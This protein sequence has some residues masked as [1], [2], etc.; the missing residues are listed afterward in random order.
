VLAACKDD[1]TAPPIDAFSLA[2]HVTQPDGTPV[3]GLSVVLWNL[4][5]S[6]DPYL[7]DNS[8]GRRR[9]ATVVDFAMARPALVSLK[10]YDLEGRLRQTVLDSMVLQAGLHSVVLGSGLE[11][12][13]GVEVLRYELVLHDLD[14]QVE[15]F[16]DENY[17]TAVHLDPAR[18][19][20]G[21]TDDDGV[22]ET[23]DR[24]VL[25][26]LYELGDLTATDENGKTTGSFTLDPTLVLRIYDD[27]GTFLHVETT[28]EDGPNRINALWDPS[29]LRREAR[30]PQ[31]TVHEEAAPT[32]THP[33]VPDF[34]LR[35]NYPNPFN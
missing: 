35:Q 26:G 34:E 27:Q 28:M 24:T 16:R 3:E 4:S 6:L 21:I 30:G 13:A 12:H 23:L 33:V 18:L 32:V 20:A 19:I 29:V 8:Q 7:Q 25:P 15:L 1:T 14:S 17:M 5:P 31:D 2:V 10:V 9:A 22:Y 11:F